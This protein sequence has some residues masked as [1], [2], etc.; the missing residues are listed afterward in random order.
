[1]LYSHISEALTDT[2]MIAEGSDAD[3]GNPATMLTKN[4]VPVLVANYLD[5]LGVTGQ[6]WISTSELAAFYSLPHGLVLQ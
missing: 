6:L 3:F 1:L 2:L 5:S 4:N